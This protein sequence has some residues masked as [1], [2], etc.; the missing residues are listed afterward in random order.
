MS[1][2]LISISLAI[3]LIM[4]PFIAF[5]E[6]DGFSNIKIDYVR[7]SGKV[8]ISGKA[9]F[10]E[11]PDEP[12]RLMVLKP[13]PIGDD[14]VSNIEA[15]INGTVNLKDV[16]I[17]LDET[18]LSSE[19]TFTFKSFVMPDTLLPGDYVVRLA[20]ETTEYTVT[21]SFASPS[22][23]IEILNKAEDGKEVLSCI[24]KYNDVYNL[25][26]SEESDYA[27]LTSEGKDFVL[28]K[29]CAEDFEDESD[30]KEI[31]DTSVQ[32]Y[33][34]YMGPWGVME[35]IIEKHASLLGI[36]SYIDD[37][38]DLSQSKK[39]SVYKELSGNLYNDVKEFGDA[40]DEAVTE[41][42]SQTE[43][44]KK[45][46][47][48]SH[49]GGSGR[50]TSQ[51]T[52]PVATKAPADSTESPDEDQKENEGNSQKNPFDDLINHSWA[53]ES[54]L[55]LYNKGII[56]G[57][58]NG[59]F[60]PNDNVTRA[61]AV[62]MIALAFNITDD[63]A[64]CSFSDVKED[65][66]MYPYIAA[67]TEK[68]IILGYNADTF[69][70][71]DS[72]TREDFATIIVRTIKVMGTELDETETL[73]NFK[74]SENISEYAKEAVEILQKANILNGTD[75]NLFMPKKTTTRA[76]ASKVIAALLD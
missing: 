70:T 39:D 8:T 65:S 50:V 38:K 75:D 67:A 48:S 71:N 76:E 74:D 60:A 73:Q 16:C 61:E 29:L 22:Q 40:F 7:N 44:T 15:L 9:A 14:A 53:E 27:D 13:D 6:V 3:I 47:A 11:N 31:F 43:N 72:I 10:M 26:T 49:G 59:K 41:A 66:W 24:E 18:V 57:K 34:I 12:V 5:G 35:E 30:V 68:E 20:G 19:K 52:V 62:K 63:L 36:S 51:V 54:I 32:L 28:E 2:R 33:R 17:H 58:G 42:A 4:C 56:N 64:K 23:T 37:Y 69:G 46:P 55:K 1:K 25:D 45:E 21:L